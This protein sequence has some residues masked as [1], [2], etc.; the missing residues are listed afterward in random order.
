MQSILV[1][2]IS[3]DSVVYSQLRTMVYVSSL[4]FGLLLIAALLRSVKDGACAREIAATNCAWLGFVLQSSI[5]LG[6]Q[7]TPYDVWMPL[8]GT[9]FVFFTV[10][11]ILLVASLLL[12]ADH[13][14]ARRFGYLASWGSFLFNLV[15]LIIMLRVSVLFTAP[16]PTLMMVMT[17]TSGMSVYYLHKFNS[18]NIKKNDV[19]Q[20][21]FVQEF[22]RFF[23]SSKVLAAIVASVLILDSIA[24]VQS[25]DYWVSTGNPSKD[26][27]FG[28][29]FGGDTTTEAKLLIDR[30]KNYTNVFVVDSWPISQNEAALNEICNYAVDSGL[31]IIVHF[32]WFGQYWQAYWLDTAAQ[33]WGEK[34]LGVYLYDEPGGVQ[35]DSRGSKYESVNPL[36]NNLEEATNLYLR[37]FQKANHGKSDMRMLKMRHIR[38]FTSDYALYWFDYDAGYDVLFA[39]FGWNYSRQLNVAFVRGAAT[40]QNRDWGVI[41]TYTY[42]GAPYIESGEELY[43][44]MILAY[45]NG[46]NYILVFNYPYDSNSTYGILKEEHLEALRKFWNY[47]NCNPRTS[48]SLSSRVAYVLPKDYAYG[49]RGPNDTIW[50]FWEADSLSYNL[51]VNLYNSMEQ[52]GNRL[53]VIYDDGIAPNNTSL[54]DEFVFWNGTVTS[55]LAL[56]SSSEVFHASSPV[57]FCASLLITAILG[58]LTC[59]PALLTIRRRRGQSSEA[60]SGGFAAKA[61][62]R[63]LGSGTLELADNT[64]KFYMERGYLKKQKKTVRNIPMTDIENI[65]QV[66]NEIR[67]TWKGITDIFDME[68]TESAGA[69]YEKA[70]D[71]LKEQNKMLEDKEDKEAAKQ[72]QSELAHVLNVAIGIVDSLFDV[73]RSLHGRVDW[74]RVEICL[75]RSEENARNLA[76]QKIGIPNLEFTKL[77]LAVKERLPEEISAEAYSILRSLYEYFSRLSE[78][79]FPEHIHPNYQDTKTTITAYYTL[80]D[81]VLG[82]IV[83]DKEIEKESNELVEMLDEL[84]KRTGL[85]MNVEAIKEIL[86]KLGMEKAEESVI[87]ETRSVFKQQL[88]ELITA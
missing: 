8:D 29:T 73:L 43:N 83:E 60:M 75:S 41:V 50:G 37:S 14:W 39:E 36:P 21:R 17:S 33:R 1:L 45:N 26:F 76:D 38:A 62:L 22:K 65:E 84:S 80:N 78:N 71:A 35:L 72:K 87:E 18:K 82:T 56:K 49:F 58:M 77:S 10:T 9:L 88:K 25:N 69:I 47:A 86:N 6:L 79:E 48:S 59:A 64:I 70:I 66:G 81:I 7:W 74:N 85:E 31:R 52:Y 68:K 44:D 15:G 55:M 11:V 12:L 46:A 54:Y 27:F 20:Q 51:S 67:I 30:V 34:F 4:G 53:D 24:F 32:A 2:G 40:V 28:V 42:N 23:S 61:S 57:W 3:T 5:G 19:D 16:F 13:G 63:T